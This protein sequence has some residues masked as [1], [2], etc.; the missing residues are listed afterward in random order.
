MPGTPP[1]VLTAPSPLAVAVAELDRAD[2][3]RAWRSG[4]PAGDPTWTRC[5]DVDAEY[6]AEWEH[7]VAERHRGRLRRQ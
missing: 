3:H 7:A 2:E 6:V 1:S 4:V 5:T